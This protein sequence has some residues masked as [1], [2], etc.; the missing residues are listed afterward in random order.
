MSR[1]LGAL[2]ELSDALGNLEYFAGPRAGY[3]D[4]VAYGL[5][6]VALVVLPPSHELRTMIETCT[7]LRAFV[8]RMRRA[9]FDD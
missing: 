5:F 3:V 1:A 4:A 2:K 7:R 6:A 9:L 8:G